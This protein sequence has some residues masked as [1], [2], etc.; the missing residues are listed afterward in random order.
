MLSRAELLGQ[1]MTNY[2][3]PV[4]ISGTHGKTTTT[5]MLSHIALA[6]D[7]DPTISVGGILKAIEGNIRVGGPD[8]FI[9]EACEYTNSFLH[10]F[11]KI[12]IILN[13]DADHLDFFKDLDDIRNSFHLLLS[14]FRKTELSSSTEI[15]IKLKRSPP[16]FPVVLLL[17]AKK[18]PWITV[19]PILLITNRAMPLS[20]S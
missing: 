5:S 2:K 15:L 20:M 10:F 19:Q 8:L 7:L 3:T 6:A 1:L 9:T 17:L 11:P 16:I 14:F 13:V 12:G 4:A 18:L